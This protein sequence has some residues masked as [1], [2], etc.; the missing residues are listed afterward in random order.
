MNDYLRA[1][2]V[3]GAFEKGIGHLIGHLG[4]PLEVVID[5][6]GGGDA[7]LAIDEQGNLRQVDNWKSIKSYSSMSA[8]AFWEGLKWTVIPERFA[9]MPS[10]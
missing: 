3:R 5:E 1:N 2:I 7:A 9:A 6:K 4:V 10:E 8:A